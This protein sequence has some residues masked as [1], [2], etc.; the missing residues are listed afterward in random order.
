MAAAA[1]RTTAR[2]PRPNLAQ[3]DRVRERGYSLLAGRAGDARS[4]TRRRWRRSRPPTGCPGTSASVQPA[5]S[6]LADLFCPDLRPGR[7]YD[8]ANVVVPVPT[9]AG[10]PPMALRMTG[11]P[12]AASTQQIQHWIDRLTQVATTVATGPA[13]TTEET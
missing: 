7:S 12:A 1:R 6:E 4:G 8:L 10:Q 3:L 13:T 11:L 9:A 2:T 5:T